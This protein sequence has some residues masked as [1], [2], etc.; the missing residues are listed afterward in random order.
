MIKCVNGK[1]KFVKKGDFYMKKLGKRKMSSC[2]FSLIVVMIC[3]LCMLMI[4][5]P[6]VLSEDVSA[7]LRV[8]FTI[9]SIVIATTIGFA[10]YVMYKVHEL[11]EKQEHDEEDKDGDI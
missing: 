1:I 3:I 2:M 8:L 11:F 6:I 7:E 5:V 9:F 4:M 10:F